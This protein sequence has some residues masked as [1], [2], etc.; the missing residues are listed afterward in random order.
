MLAHPSSLGLDASTRSNL[1]KTLSSDIELEVFSELQPYCA[2]LHKMQSYTLARDESSK[3]LLW[4]LSHSPV[5]TQ[6]QAGKKE[7]ILNPGN[8]PIIQSDRGGQVTYHGPGQLIVYTLWDL[9]RLGCNI[10]QFVQKLEKSIILL[11]QDYDIPGEIREGA[12]GVYVG[13]TKICSLGLRVKKGCAYHGLALNVDMDLSPFSR[14]NPCGFKALSISQIKHFLP[15][16][17]FEQ[18]CQDLLPHLL[19]QLNKEPL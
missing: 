10:K 7:H 5:F 19:A 2:T 18:V 14:I 3:D 17:T 15:N 9:K 13:E 6:G 11:L 4:F 1:K 8:I 12:P 16:I